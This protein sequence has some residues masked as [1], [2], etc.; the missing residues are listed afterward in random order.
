MQAMVIHS[1]TKEKGFLNMLHNARS[2]IEL[3]GAIKAIKEI[4]GKNK[5]YFLVLQNNDSVK[6]YQ[7][8]MVI[9]GKK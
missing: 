2:G 8:N 5:P 1:S 3:N 9:A 4:P 7:R 6:L